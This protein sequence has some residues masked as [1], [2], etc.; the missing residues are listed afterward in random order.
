M[1]RSNDYWVRGSELE[2][3]QMRLHKYIIDRRIPPTRLSMAVIGNSAIHAALSGCMVKRTTLDKYA[4][5]M[6]QN[7]D[8][9]PDLGDAREHD[10]RHALFGEK[11]FGPQISEDEITR[12]RM[13][14]E[15]ER[16]NHVSYWLQKERQA[17]PRY[18]GKMIPVEDMPA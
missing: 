10:R 12:R 1:S 4:R 3:F 14:R 9:H 2:I 18:F 15:T 6:D 13:D 7:P 11:S 5:F 16:K 17:A 8:G